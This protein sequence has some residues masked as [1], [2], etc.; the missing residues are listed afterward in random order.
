MTLEDIR[1]VFKKRKKEQ[2]RMKTAE[3][4]NKSGKVPESSK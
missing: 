2:K 3:N 4:S 1:S